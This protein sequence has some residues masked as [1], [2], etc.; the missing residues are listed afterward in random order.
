M[1][2]KILIA[3]ALLSGVTNANVYDNLEVN[4]WDGSRDAAITRHA[5][6][7]TG[8]DLYVYVL[9]AEIGISKSDNQNLYFYEYRINNGETLKVC[10]EN[11]DLDNEVWNFNGTNVKMLS[12]CDA[13][14][15]T[16]YYTAETNTG[17]AH[18]VKLFKAATKSV[19]IKTQQRT[20]E[21]SSQG[22][23]KLWNAHGGNAI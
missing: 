16:A 22:F 1:I 20:T 13:R 18:V 15:N 2:K 6:S 4:R 3:T 10:E 9:I 14:D 21:V 12:L 11:D 17:K 23:T 8:I 5:V 7:E 19:K